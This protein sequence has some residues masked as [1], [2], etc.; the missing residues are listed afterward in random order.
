MEAGTDMAIVHGLRPVAN[1]HGPQTSSCSDRRPHG[2]RLIRPVYV[3][4]TTWLANVDL[5]DPRN[6][7]AIYAAGKHPRSNSTTACIRTVCGGP[8]RSGV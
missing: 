2:L 7:P 5:A 6:T 1:V 3:G 4:S 8:G